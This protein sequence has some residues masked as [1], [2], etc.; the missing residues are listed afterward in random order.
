MIH[1]CVPPD[2]IC[3]YEQTG[4]RRGRKLKKGL[5]KIDDL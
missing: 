5:L 3:T 4:C 2:K 1:I